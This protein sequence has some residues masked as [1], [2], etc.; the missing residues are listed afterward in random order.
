[1]VGLFDRDVFLKLA[2]LGLWDEVLAATGVTA[3][4]RLPSCSV[5]GSA[6]VLRRWLKDP[7][8]LQAAMDRL[9]A[10]AAAVPVVD[11]GLA[12]AARSAPSFTDLAN[13]DD[14]DAGEALLVGMLEAAT[15]PAVL[16]T[17]DKRF[18]GALRTR[19][20][21]RYAALAGRVL[22]LERCLALVCQAHGAALVVGKA[23]P[24][25]ACDGSLRIALGVPPGADHASFLEALASFDPCRD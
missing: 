5:S 21:V 11:E 7:A 25:A 2:C 13:T 9:A 16:L 20:P 22:S 23:I 14:I 24:V 19:H 6:S 8:I 17:G 3:P 18:V 15:N 1:L 10:I 4:Y 12:A